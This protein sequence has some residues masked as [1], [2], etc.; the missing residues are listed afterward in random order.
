MI[1]YRIKANIPVIIMGETGYGKTSLIIKLNQLLHNGEK[2]IRVININPC[3]NDKDICKEMNLIN[4]DAKKIKDEIWVCF[5]KINTCLSL[6]LL[7]EIFMNRTYNG[8]KINDNIRLIG[9]CNPYRKR[10]TEIEILGLC[11]D[12]DNDT[13]TDNKLEYLV[14]PLP[15]SLLYY[16]FNFGSINEE[17]EKKYIYYIIEKL[18]TSEEKKLHEITREAIFECHK[19]LRVILGPSIISLREISRFIKLVIF[20]QKYFS[21]KD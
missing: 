21:I 1:L 20:F 3:L 12:D 9:E 18:F 8:E 14:Q 15:Q 5:N 4:E 2:T 7:T 16:V 10:K 6:P 19:Y 17:D 11:L 13:D